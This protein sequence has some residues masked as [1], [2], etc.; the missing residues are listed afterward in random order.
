MS[1]FFDLRWETV[2][3]EF[4]GKI[5]LL[6]QK[7]AVRIASDRLEQLYLQLGQTGAE[8]VICR[9]LEELAVRLSYTERC[10][11]EGKLR[12]MRKSARGLIAIA[13]QIGMERVALVAQDVVTCIDNQ[14]HVAMEA[15]L[16]RLLRIGEC[17]LFEIWDL[18]DYSF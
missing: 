4:V 10:L 5:T 17:S 15:T 8:D 12:E 13:D 11:R 1:Q 18:Q 2:W 14:D 9:A 7:E 6:E 16:A 3:G